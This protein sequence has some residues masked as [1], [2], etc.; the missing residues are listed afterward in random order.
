[1]EADGRRTPLE[2]TVVA[3][4]LQIRVPSAVV[5]DARYPAVLD[6]IISPEIGFDQPHYVTQ[7]RVGLT[8]WPGVAWNG[9]EF[10]VVWV[11]SRMMALD[12]SHPIGSGARG[13][14]WT[15]ASSIK[16]ASASAG[17]ATSPINSRRR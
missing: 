3:G 8:T 17:R 4:E 16:E 5:D 12:R 6:P 15:G 9:S 2:T 7:D 14:P 11:D 10:L 1:V 13:W